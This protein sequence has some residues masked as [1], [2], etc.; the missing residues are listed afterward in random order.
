M[1]FIVHLSSFKCTEIEV[2]QHKESFT[3]KLEVCETK[4]YVVTWPFLTVCH[5]VI[6]KGFMCYVSVY[7]CLWKTCYN[8]CLLNCRNS[9]END[10]TPYRSA[11]SVNLVSVQYSILL[12]TTVYKP[13][14]IK[15]NAK[16]HL[17]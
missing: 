7:A 12:A 15:I 2:L 10:V 5:Q 11:I 4:T 8:F 17:C 16:W 6:N 13:L 14:L 9:N 1:F 3:L